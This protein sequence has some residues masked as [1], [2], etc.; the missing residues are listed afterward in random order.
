MK[1]FLLTGLFIALLCP[2]AAANEMT[3]DYFDIATNYCIEGNYSQAVNYLDKILAIEPDN[4]SVSDLKNG[5][6]RII[7]G[8]NT[9][10]IL[11][12]SNAVKQAVDCKK[13]GD[14]QGE[15]NALAAGTDYWAYYFLGDYY[16]QNKN[17]QQAISYFV[18]SVNA[19]PSFTQCYLQIAICYFES[20]NYYQTITYLNQYLKI[21]PQDDFAYALRARAQ[22]NL[23]DCDSA[24]SDILTAMALE[25]S[26]DYRFLEGK[27]LYKMKRYSQALQKLEK[28]ADEIRTAEVY[29]YIGLSYAE[30]GNENQA[31]LNLDKS[32]LLFEDDKTVQDRYNEIKSRI[33][34]AT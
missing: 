8:K 7:Q 32:L 4:K 29:K 14:K 5:L 1:K 34:N 17:Y 23:G 9:S 33:K 15:M 24:L 21:N 31:L 11:P 25:N 13:S 10:F 27:I 12:K 18:K 30:L 19:K 16:R 20:K 2:Y 3:E 6:N 22:V 26:I 28:L